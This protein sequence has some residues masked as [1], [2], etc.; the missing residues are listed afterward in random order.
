MQS[1]TS[2][3][4]S[5]RAIPHSLLLP[6]LIIGKTRPELCSVMV[7]LPRCPGTYTKLGPSNLNAISKRALIGS[8]RDRTVQSAYQW[9]LEISEA[10]LYSRTPQVRSDWRALPNSPGLRAKGTTAVAIR[11][12]TTALQ[13]GF[14]LRWTSIAT[15]SPTANPIRVTYPPTMTPMGASTSPAAAISSCHDDRHT[16]FARRAGFGTAT[17]AERGTAAPCIV[18]LFKLA[19]QAILQ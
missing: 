17:G 13:P 9:L 12:T 18:T 16:W 7:M 5:I 15:V 8:Y 11:P 14:T 4:S 19:R 1:K 10:I 6:L 2:S 3:S